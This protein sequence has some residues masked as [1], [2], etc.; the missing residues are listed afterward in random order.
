MLVKSAPEAP[1]LGRLENSVF[2]SFDRLENSVITAYRAQF[3]T[4]RGAKLLNNRVEKVRHRFPPPQTDFE[5][6]STW[7]TGKLLTK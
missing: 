4:K 5:I 3:R 1:N 6:L 7:L 2:V